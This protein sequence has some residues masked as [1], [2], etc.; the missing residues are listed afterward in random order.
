MHIDTSCI[1]LLPTIFPLHYNLSSLES[2]GAC[3]SQFRGDF[4]NNLYVCTTAYF[5]FLITERARYYTKLLHRNSKAA[6]A[7]NTRLVVQHL[8]VIVSDCL[9]VPLGVHT[10]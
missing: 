9:P 8:W 3:Q 7:C 2:L 6:F 1:N 5:T 4:V 10:T